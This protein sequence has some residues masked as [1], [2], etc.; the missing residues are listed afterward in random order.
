MAARNTKSTKKTKTAKTT[1]PSASDLAEMWK[2]RCYGTATILLI[3]ILGLLIGGV[4]LYM[5]YRD[6]IV[7]DEDVAALAVYDEVAESFV[8]GFDLKEGAKTYADVNSYG[9]SPDGD[10]YIGYTLNELDGQ[11]NVTSSKNG[12]IYFWTDKEDGHRSYG[13]SYDE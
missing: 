7:S 5:N 13:F 12:K 6:N 9:V 4:G 11:N 1:K 10:F 8:N 3:I 2:S